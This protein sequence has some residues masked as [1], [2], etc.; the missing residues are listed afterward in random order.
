MLRICP[1]FLWSLGGPIK[2]AEMKFKDGVVMMGPPC[3]EQG[4]KSP[5]E[6][7]GLNQRLYIYVDHVDEKLV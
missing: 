7:A 3:D 5:R 6:P 4:S 2:Y 1:G